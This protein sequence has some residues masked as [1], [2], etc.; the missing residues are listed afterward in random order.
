MTLTA[1]E[2]IRL[3]TSDRPVLRRVVWTA[4]GEGQ[5]IKLEFRDASTIKVWQD[6]NLLVLAVD[7]TV[8][9]VNSVVHVNALPLVNSEFVIEYTS[10][11]FTDEELQLFLDEASGDT[12]LASAFTLWAWA[13]DAAKLAKK[14]SASGG[15]GFG[16]VTLDLAVRARELREAAKGYMDQYQLFEGVGVPVEM[17]TEVGW[18]EETRRRMIIRQI[19]GLDTRT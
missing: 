3:K 6:D 7:Y 19:L 9:A 18:T 13:A 16:A 5:D 4:D 8:D 1:I 14:E 15:G 17:L 10:N 11:V 2:A 12:T